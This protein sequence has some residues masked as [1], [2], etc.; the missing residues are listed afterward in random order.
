[1]AEAL[2]LEEIRTRTLVERQVYGVRMAM[3]AEE[4]DVDE[5]PDVDKAVELFYERLSADDSTEDLSPEDER[6]VA[7][8]LGKKRR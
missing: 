7:L 6:R 2:W 3:H 1:V 4:F 8:G 5:L